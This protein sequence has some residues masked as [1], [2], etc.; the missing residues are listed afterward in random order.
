MPPGFC[1][2][3]L[4]FCLLVEATPLLAQSLDCANRKVIVQVVDRKGVLVPDL[5]ASD[6]E[7][8][9]NGQPVTLTSAQRHHITGRVVLLLDKSGSM[10]YQYG[11]FNADL[12]P[13]PSEQMVLEEFLASLPPS[14][15]VALMFFGEKVESKTGFAETRE[16]LQQVASQEFRYSNK[17]KSHTALWDAILEAALLLDKTQVG[18]SIVVVSDGQDNHSKHK[19]PEVAKIL[20]NQGIRLFVFLPLSTHSQTTEEASAAQDLTQAAAETGGRGVEQEILDLSWQPNRLQVARNASFIF[21]R[22]LAGYELEIA[23]PV[24]LQKPQKWTLKIKEDIKAKKKIARVE[25]PAR[26][27]PC[28]LSAGAGVR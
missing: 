5:V 9:Y 17:W 8:S 16:K 13:T 25:Y 3:A 27:M 21:W 2:P 28:P 19:Q 6:F 4:I 7:A 20:L 14:V 18:D 11:N 15:P 24:A 1:T 12:Q 22:F 23:V 10:G 26:L